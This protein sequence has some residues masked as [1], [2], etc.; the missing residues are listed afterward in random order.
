MSYSDLILNITDINAIITLSQTLVITRKQLYE[1]FCLRFYRISLLISNQMSALPR[2]R[3]PDGSSVAAIDVHTL[4][5]FAV[6][7]DTFIHH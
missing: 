4:S 1:S 6:V 2:V 7:V 3:P 5:L